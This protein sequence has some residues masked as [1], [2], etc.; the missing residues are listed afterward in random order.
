MLYIQYNIEKNKI[1]I[2]KQQPALQELTCTKAMVGCGIEF[3]VSNI[4]LNAMAS[5]K[6]SSLEYVVVRFIHSRSAPAQKLLPLDRINTPRKSDHSANIYTHV[7]IYSSYSK[8]FKASK[9]LKY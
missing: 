3:R 6:F 8:E 5:L 9:T 1:A 4:L 7:D 2:I